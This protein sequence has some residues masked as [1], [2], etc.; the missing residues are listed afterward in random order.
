MEEPAFIRGQDNEKDVV[1]GLHIIYSQNVLLTK[2]A[3]IPCILYLIST[4][5]HWKIKHHRYNH[6]MKKKASWR[7]PDLHESEGDTYSS[8]CEIID[9]RL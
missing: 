9:D 6:R 8:H 2:H 3:Y 5:N 4:G 7:E 1:G